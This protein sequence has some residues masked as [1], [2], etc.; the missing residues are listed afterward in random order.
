[1]KKS[2]FS[3]TLSLMM[4]L[5]LLAG[6]KVN[7]RK[8]SRGVERICQRYQESAPA[9]QQ[10]AG[11]AR[12]RFLALLTF[13]QPSPSSA[14]LVDEYGCTVVDSIGRI[15][16]VSIPVA[17]VGRLSNDP[18]VERIEAE[19]APRPA[20]DV[21]P[22]QVN[23]SPV[24]VGTQ[25]P[26]AYTGAGVVAGVF[27]TGFDFTHPSFYDEDGELRVKYYY[28]FYWPNDDGTLGRA[29]ENTDEIA[30]YAHS[31]HTA[32]NTHATHVMGIMAGSPVDGK[33]QGMAPEADIY[34]A[35]F[36]SYREEFANPDEQTSATAVL[37]FKY[38]FDKAERE[39]KPCVINFSSCESITLSR[40]R[41]LE[42]EA[43]QA[44]SGP[45]RI[46]VAAVGN[47][48]ERSCYMEKGDANR[49]GAAIINGI[50][51]GGLI[52]LDIVTPVNQQV[53][54]DFLSIRLIDPH[55]EKTLIFNTDSIDSL[56][57]DT[58]HLSVDVS[59]GQV[60]LNIYRSDYQDERGRVYHVEG[61]MPDITYLM[62]YGAL[63]L[64]TG[65]GPAWIYSDLFYSPLVNLQG[66][67]VYSHTSLGYSVCWP[68]SLEGIVGVGATGY[69]WS[70]TNIDGNLNSDMDIFKPESKG[71]VAK[72]SS[73]GPTFDGR[74]K[75]DVVAPGM[76]INAAYNSFSKN[77]DAERKEITDKVSFNGKDYYFFAQSGTSMA[78]PVVSGAVALWLQA[79][80][81]LTAE[82][83]IDIIA[84]TATHPDPSMEYP[85]NIYGYGQIDVYA[86]LLY[87][88]DVEHVIPLLSRHQPEQA[89]FLLS[90]RR[91]T[92][93]WCADAADLQ[94]AVSLAVY[95]TDG[96][97][98]A[99]YSI[100]SRHPEV[101]L[102]ALPRGVYAVQL[103]TGHEA[104]TGSTLIRLDD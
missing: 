55:I 39:G 35:D 59:A 89:R 31:Q 79:D 57:G 84:H 8:V 102:S 21:T 73:R 2:V 29:L 37:G 23:A 18:R 86:G 66:S 92:V 87:L 90:Q 63:C 78:A 46:I 36:N 93:E 6:V 49:A 85:N 103:S 52:D 75:P 33:Y 56:E 65:N 69:K 47:D 38:I 83:V 48:G 96:R 17:E 72:F 88:L 9:T 104:T 45:G 25:L 91:L 67:D 5:P 50:G 1:M 95:T 20:M 22:G 62:L 42:G 80:P 81:T 51:G 77:Y 41:I 76:S 64:L 15:Y 14:V 61:R 30:S 100:D 7:P 34:A 12:P 44:L 27:D 3:L 98:V 11:Y 32:E 26:Q 13:T 71:R 94:S 97:Q 101:D 99:N 43:L 19:P 24:Y 74:V 82:R 54:F 60:Q 40:Q 53:R 10:V 4:V 58:C 28:D 70:F 16:I 68:A